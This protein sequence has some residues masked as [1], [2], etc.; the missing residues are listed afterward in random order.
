MN[1]IGCLEY[2]VAKAAQYGVP[3][4]EVT[5]T[6]EVGRMVRKG[7]A[8]K[9]DKLAD[10]F[11]IAPDARPDGKIGTPQYMLERGMRK[12]AYV[13][14]VMFAGF[15]QPALAQ[16]AGDFARVLQF[17]TTLTDAA[18][19]VRADAAGN[20]YVAG[21]TS[22][23]L[24][25]QSSKGGVDAFIRKYDPDGLELWTRQFGTSA[26]DI[27][28]SVFPFGGDVYVGGAT[29]GALGGSVGLND[30]FLRKLDEH[31][32]V[33]WTLQ[34]G[35]SAND[36]A[37]GLFVDE[38][39]VCAVGQANGQAAAS[40]AFLLKFTHDGGVLWNLQINSGGPDR[41]Y[42]VF[43]D[44]SGVYV[45]GET[46][47]TLPGQISAGSTDAFMRKYDLEGAEQWTRQFGTG[48]IDIAFGVASD[49][50]G[51]YVAGRAG[52]AL[53]G[54]FQGGQYDAFVRKYDREGTEVWTRQF[55][56]TSNDL[57]HGI[58][59]R[60]YVV[61]VSGQTAGTLPGQQ[62]SW[63]GDDVFV[64]A[65]SFKGTELWTRQ[66]GTPSAEDSWSVA[67][68]PSG[69]HVVGSTRGTLEGG[70]P[71]FF[72]DAFVVNLVPE[73][74]ATIA[75]KPGSETAP[76]RRGAGFLPV[77]ILSTDTFDANTI[78]LATLSLEGATL[79]VKPRGTPMA[80]SEDVNG[81]GLYDLVVHLET[82]EF[83]PLQDETLTELV[84]KTIGG[85]VVFGVGQIRILR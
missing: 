4:E 62:R 6:V 58:E 81:D 63:L 78:D 41:A 24:P 7:A 48:G 12:H 9:M 19:S 38:T 55:G 45:V 35:T 5:Q 34:Y 21:E 85:R 18:W 43:G 59:A 47:G 65:Y 27:A 51:T 3:Q 56:T 11:V 57:A 82:D 46:G 8:A 84:A 79:R 31:G 80:S 49:S 74:H 14:A 25:G 32:N 22:G 75:I 71:L 17:G 72:P 29:R 73:I 10:E 13:L 42:D 60:D 39:G 20:V 40:F 28:Y 66:F 16:Q 50:T 37:R 33:L 76:I 67:G 54:Q 52:G 64:R 1:R 44:G 83:D 53:A 70:P 36:E 69:P 30:A 23:T 2:H 26:N 61:Y 15:G 77:A 68:S